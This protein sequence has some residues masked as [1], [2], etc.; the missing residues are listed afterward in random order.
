MFI[1]LSEIGSADQYGNFSGAIGMIQ[2]NVSQK[3]NE[4]SDLAENP[5]EQ[6]FRKPTQYQSQHW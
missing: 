6:V 5:N 3:L 4:P 1:S 2:R